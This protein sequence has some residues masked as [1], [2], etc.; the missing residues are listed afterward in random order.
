MLPELE[1]NEEVVVRELDL[2]RG[3]LAL[4]QTKRNKGRVGKQIGSAYWLYQHLQSISG[5]S[6]LSILFSVM[7]IPWIYIN[8][9]QQRDSCFQGYSAG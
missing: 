9:Q 2:H 7:G 1:L 6:L 3:K 4:N 5:I 8:D